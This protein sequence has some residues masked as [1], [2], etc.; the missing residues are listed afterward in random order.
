MSGHLLL[1]VV[2]QPFLAGSG[3]LWLTCGMKK[4]LRMLLLLLCLALFSG[5]CVA[6]VGSGPKTQTTYPTMG[7]QLIDLQRARDHGAI[8]PAE[9]DAAKNRILNSPW[10]Q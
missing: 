8:T 2:Q 4:N 1:S 3:G 6:S 10:P 5:G 7:Q 9:Y